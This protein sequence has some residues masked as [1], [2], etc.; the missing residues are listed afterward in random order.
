MIEEK[1]MDDRKHDEEELKL[2][3]QEVQYLF[4]T[5]DFREIVNK[6]KKKELLEMY[7]T[8]VGLGQVNSKSKKIDIATKIWEYARLLRTSQ[9]IL[10]DTW[11]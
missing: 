6:H 8:L 4:L 10:G 7:E 11:F 3:K 2:T 1:K 5:G 9:E